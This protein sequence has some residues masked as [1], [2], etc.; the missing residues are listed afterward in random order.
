LLA[1]KQKIDQLSVHLYGSPPRVLVNGAKIVDTGIFIVNIKKL[2][3]IPHQL[4]RQ[5]YVA[6]KFLGGGFPIGGE[7]CYRVKMHVRHR[8]GAGCVLFFLLRQGVARRKA[9]RNAAQAQKQNKNRTLVFHMISIFS[10]R[11]EKGAKEA[12]FS[13]LKSIT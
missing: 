7:H 11:I 9:G 6:F 1:V 4:V 3:I 12:P 10:K 5:L 2:V 13:F 8:F